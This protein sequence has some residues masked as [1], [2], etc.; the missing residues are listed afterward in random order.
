MQFRSFSLCVLALALAATG[1]F[2]QTVPATM[3]TKAESR[4]MELVGFNDLQGRSAYQPLVHRQGDRWIAYIGHHGGLSRNPLSS[5]EE[6]NGTSIL[7]VTD[8]KSPRYLAHVPGEPGKDE[9]GGAQMVQVCD[10][11]ELPRGDKGK[12][13]LLR[14]YGDTA[15][16]IWDVTDP[17]KPARLSTVVD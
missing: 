4:D 10:G 9:A 15:H 13:Y 5:T 3:K 11:S 7:D 14:N 12:V 2:A 16:E 8:P 17:A 6:P 1:T